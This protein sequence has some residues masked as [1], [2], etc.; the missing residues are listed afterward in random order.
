L[1][2]DSCLLVVDAGL[3]DPDFPRVLSDALV[4]L[5]P[6]PVC[7]GRA[8]VVC[9]GEGIDSLVVTQVG[10]LIFLISLSLLF[11]I[12]VGGLVLVGRLFLLIVIFKCL[13]LFI[14]YFLLV[15]IRNVQKA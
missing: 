5:P 3:L 15:G 14:D 6:G 2:L 1:F 12:L 10:Q 13:T 9:V 11:L 8:V 7:W 4:E